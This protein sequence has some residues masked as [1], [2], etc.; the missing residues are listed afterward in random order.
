[1]KANKNNSLIQMIVVLMLSSI[2][3]VSCSKEDSNSGA[4]NPPVI[5][6]VYASVKEN[7]QPADLIPLTQGY[8]N[9]YYIINGSGFT[10]LKK[11]YFNDT[12]A[13]FNSNFVTDKSIVV[14]IDKDTPYANASNKLKIVTANGIA[15]FDFVVAPPAPTL[16]SFNPINAADGSVVTLYGS[17]FLNPVITVGNSQATIVSSN[18]N[19]VKI[20]LPAGSNHKQIKV[21]T[22]SGSSTYYAAVGTAIFD[23]VFYTP[24]TIESW[25]NHVFITDA[26]AEQ[27]TTYYKKSMDAWGNIQGNWDWFDQIA[28]YKGIRLAIKADKVGKIKLVFNGNWNDATAPILDVTKEWKVF[29]LTWSDL[30]NADHVQNISFQNFTKTPTGDGDA[31]VFYFDNFGYDIN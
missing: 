3:L 13:P 25:N 16:K 17:F 1:M 28:P 7:G 21:T 15:E 23:D 31:N 19:E 8:A 20:I 14:L 29:H 26:N 6:S 27:G 4:S 18:L 9:N 10:T 30:L 5:S 24:W 12:E 2:F 22:I 11:V